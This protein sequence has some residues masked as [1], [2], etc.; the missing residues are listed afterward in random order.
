MTPSKTRRVC[1]TLPDDDYKQLRALLPHGTQD[2]LFATIARQLV[3]KI[4]AKQREVLGGILAGEI[5]V[6]LKLKGVD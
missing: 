2:K 5:E 4:R 3:P 6:E 1:F